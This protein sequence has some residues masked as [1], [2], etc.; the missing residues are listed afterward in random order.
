MLLGVLGAGLVLEEGRVRRRLV[1][2]EVL[3]GIV[4][5]VVVVVIVV[6]QAK[7][8]QQVQQA[9]AGVGVMVKR[10]GRVGMPWT[11]QSR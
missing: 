3:E 11:A 6:E 1:L 5:A 8:A 9:A 10:P 7:H 2:G 4:V